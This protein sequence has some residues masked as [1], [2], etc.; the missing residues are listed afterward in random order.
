ML[1]VNQDSRLHPL[2]EHN[3]NSTV[4]V[5]L[6][7]GDDGLN[8]DSQPSLAMMEK[9]RTGEKESGG[10]LTPRDAGSFTPMKN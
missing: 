7:L 2:L 9:H 10:I 3:S 5:K 4:N 8:I 6:Q 1:K